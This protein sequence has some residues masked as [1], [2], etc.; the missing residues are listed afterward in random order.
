FN[1]SCAVHTGSGR[2]TETGWVFI[3]AIRVMTPSLFH[4]GD[5]ERT[6]LFVYQLGPGAGRDPFLGVP[7]SAAMD[8][9]LRRDLNLSPCSRGETL[10]RCFGQQHRFRRIVGDAGGLEILDLR[11][12]A[13]ALADTPQPR[14]AVERLG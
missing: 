12:H 2:G 1:S 4:H 14:P 8:P 11:V 13:V 6:E 7:A 10:F 9:G 5:V 3:S